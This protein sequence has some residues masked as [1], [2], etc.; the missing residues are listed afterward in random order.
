MTSIHLWYN[1]TS[2]IQSY[3][4]IHDH[5]FPTMYDWVWLCM[6]HSLSTIN[7]RASC[8]LMYDFEWFFLMNYFNAKLSLMIKFKYF[9]TTQFICSCI[10]GLFQKS[11]RRLQ[12]W[13]HCFIENPFAQHTAILS[14]RMGINKTEKSERI[15]RRTSQTVIKR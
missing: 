14:S 15:K 12:F 3:M 6:N 5:F 13:R 2:R 11:I 7:L 1:F 8:M 9:T 4:L 10:T